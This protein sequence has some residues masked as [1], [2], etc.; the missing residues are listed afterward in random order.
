MAISH[1]P[2]LASTGTAGV[3]GPHCI[4]HWEGACWRSPLGRAP[5]YA[6]RVLRSQPSKPLAQ[7]REA[8]CWAI[9]PGRGNAIR[10]ALPIPTPSQTGSLPPHPVPP[11]PRLWL[12]AGSLPTLSRIASGCST[13]S[14]P[15]ST[16][17]SPGAIN[18]LYCTS[19]TP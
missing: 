9:R 5:A 10:P 12:P 11:S 4:Q 13:C 8:L 3:S 16:A 2:I 18:V 7:V 1:S 15:T 14:L 17:C 19:G 6:M